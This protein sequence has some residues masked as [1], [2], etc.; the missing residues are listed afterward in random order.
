MS[1]AHQL[2]QVE[3]NTQLLNDLSDDADY[4]RIIAG[5]KQSNRLEQQVKK[6][7]V[8]EEATEATT[9]DLMEDV[10]EA[11]IQQISDEDYE[12]ILAA[13]AF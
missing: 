8:D 3:A 5:V 9:Y 13:I 1:I 4:D 12:A 11:A 6:Y 2:R 10:S 7:P